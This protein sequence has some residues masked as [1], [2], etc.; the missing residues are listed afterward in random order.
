LSRYI[1]ANGFEY[2]FVLEF[3]VLFPKP[4]NTTRRINQLLLSGKKGMA[5]GTNFYADVLFCR[6]YLDDVAAGTLDGR[7]LV[8]GMYV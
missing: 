5:L 4:L 6:T 3:F 7:W 2:L 8:F 1:S